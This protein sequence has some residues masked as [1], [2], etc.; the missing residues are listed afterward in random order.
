MYR[1]EKRHKEGIAYDSLTVDTPSVQVICALG[2]SE[3]M[4]DWI[5]FNKT[6]A[7][8]IPRLFCDRWDEMVHYCAENE[9]KNFFQWRYKT[10]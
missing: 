8:E 1:G 10:E 4:Y 7:S 3:L 6:A 5:F 9:D 2:F